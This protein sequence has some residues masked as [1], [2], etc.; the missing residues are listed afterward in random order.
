MKSHVF[1]L[2]GWIVTTLQLSI[3][4]LAILYITEKEA[5]AYADPGSGALIWQMAVASMFG[6]LFYFR[7]FVTR[8]RSWGKKKGGK[9]EQI[10]PLGSKE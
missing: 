2:L 6:A 1:R 10:T 5:L 7:K 9:G 3:A 4:V 8:L